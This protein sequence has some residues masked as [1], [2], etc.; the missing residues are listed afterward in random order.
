MKIFDKTRKKHLV[1]TPEEG[2]R[3]RVL[4]FLATRTDPKLIAQEY[5]VDVNGQSQ[6]A[7]IVVFSPDARP[8]MVVECKAPEV[9]ISAETLAQAHRYNAVLGAPFVMLTNGADTFIYEVDENGNY[10]PVS[11]LPNLS[12]RLE[13]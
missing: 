12:A 4:A 7:D 11:E 10:L 6:R 5:P 3:R 9:R 8:L 2:V 13:K 1:L